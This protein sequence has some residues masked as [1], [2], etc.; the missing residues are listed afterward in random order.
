ML[1]IAE[2]LSVRHIIVWNMVGAYGALAC[3]YVCLYVCKGFMT[4]VYEFTYTPA[5]A[6]LGALE[7]MI[8]CKT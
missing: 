2:R 1:I 3:L 4:E 8:R 6:P 7:L 5:C